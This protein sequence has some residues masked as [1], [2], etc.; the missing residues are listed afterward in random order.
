[1]G[2]TIRV[3]DAELSLI[4]LLLHLNKDSFPRLLGYADVARILSRE[5]LDWAFIDGFV[6]EE[7]FEVAAYCSLMTVVDRL[8]LPRPDVMVPQGPRAAAW[9]AVWPEKAT[10]LGSAGSERSRRQDALPFLA[11]GR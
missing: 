1:D 11:P 6:R 3:P 5:Q 7:G 2:T 4:H 9:R 10:L 8:E